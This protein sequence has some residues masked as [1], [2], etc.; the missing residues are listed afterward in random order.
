MEVVASDGGALWEE[1]TL[2]DR[3]DR[4]APPARTV[5]SEKEGY[6]RPPRE[7]PAIPEP[8]GPPGPPGVRSGPLRST[9]P[10]SFPSRL[11]SER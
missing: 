6:E 5:G 8:G 9:P 3:E 11:G 7:Y 10:P 1:R 2:E 4:G